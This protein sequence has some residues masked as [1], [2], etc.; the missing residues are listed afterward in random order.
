[1]DE[2]IA[3][4]RGA[5]A[6]P[7]EVADLEQARHLA[8]TI[9]AQ[10]GRREQHET[11]L[12][13]L[14][15]TAHDLTLSYDLDDL[16]KVI[17]RRARQLLDFDMA[18]IS[19]RERDGTLSRIATADGETTA[20][21]VGLEVPGDSGVGAAAQANAAPF[22]T[23]D[24]LAD[25]RIRHSPTLDQVVREEGL[26]ALVAAP[27][28]HGDSVL[29]ALYGADRR[30]RHFTPQEVGLMRSLADLAAVAIQ[31]ARLFQETRAEVAELELDSSRARTTLS[32]F[33]HAADIH[34]SLINLVLS[35]CDMQRLAEDAAQA[36]QGGVLLRSPDGQLL[37]Q[38]HGA[39]PARLDEDMVAK[40]ALDAHTGRCSV[41]LDCGSW[42]APAVA[43]DEDLGSLVLQ[44]REPLGR[45]R[46]VAPAPD[47]IRLLLPLVAQATALQL[48]MQRSTA[49]A[50][51]PV[52]DELFDDLLAEPQRSAHQ[53]A[54]R[55][56]RLG[57]DLHE[58]HL[59]VVARPEGGAHGRA[60][61]WASSYALRRSGLRGVRGDRLVLLLP[62]TDAGAAAAAVAEE[63]A[64]LLGHPVTVGG[65][66]PVTES[67]AV[68]AAYREAT[69]CLQTLVSLG[70]TG[71]SAAAGDLG[72]LGVLLSG[73]YDVTR[74]VDDVIGPVLDYDRQRL[75][76]L[77]RTLE[78]YFAADSS[79][80]YAAEALHVHPNTV[81]RR[82]E[83]IT[84]LL[85]SDW[86]KPAK[87]LEVQLALRLH[88]TRGVLLARSR[89]GAGADR[90]GQAVR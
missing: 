82:L 15:D 68:P 3:E 25:E 77:I 30:V 86:Q 28:R 17:T 9:R 49:M 52:R 38:S 53:L 7:E 14:V 21:S 34:S 16:L 75:T 80:T 69:N 88:R 61:V 78:A 70:G 83:R 42:V 37:A 58:P 31:K 44:P 48:L 56:R 22:W 67:S 66:G 76:E 40:G 18:Y 4:A 79:P 41:P 2:L 74:F 33:Q 26:R 8:H 45:V 1:M 72:F 81:S 5:G 29:G 11:G 63:A 59:V 39:D 50:E 35:G 65:A 10:T 20:L 64:A 62:G 89:G 43:G 6:T 85:G 13:A 27:L 19:V 51:G 57:I 71:G 84:E 12:V 73:D 24:Y 87:A 36:L 46:N 60:A 47:R 55:A 23:S 32:E 90:G 54:E